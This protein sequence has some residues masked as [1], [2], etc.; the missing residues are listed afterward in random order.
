MKIRL[1]EEKDREYIERICLATVSD[2]RLKK[3]PELVKYLYA[4]FYMDT[5]SENIFVAVNDID[6]CVGYV[7]CAKN[8][9]VYE[10]NWKNSGYK[11]LKSL[12]LPFVILQ[13]FTVATYNN[14][15]KKGYSAHLHI[16]ID[17]KFQRLGLGH[18][19]VDAL[20]EHLKKEGVS[21]VCLDCA[22]D[23]IKGNAFYKKYGFK[24]LKEAK[25]GNIYGLTL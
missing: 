12:S 2:E 10:K 23:N 20:C 25:T 5:E 3:M 7:L 6:E 8:A 18:K 11:K 21:G 1:F 17:P 4:D 13:K 14:L 24:L 22:S 19:L 16:D 15:A 9:S